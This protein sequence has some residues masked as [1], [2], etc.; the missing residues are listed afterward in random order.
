MDI[1]NIYFQLDIMWSLKPLIY[2]FPPIFQATATVI[3]QSL[4]PKQL[5]KG[6]P[7]VETASWANHQSTAS[8]GQR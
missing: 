5:Q 7:D 4:Q 2:L 3:E 1:S 6:S 8:M